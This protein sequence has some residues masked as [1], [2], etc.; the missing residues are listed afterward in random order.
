MQSKT[1][2]K[3]TCRQHT[4][5][6]MQ[7]HYHLREYR[8]TMANNLIACWESPAPNQINHHSNQLFGQLNNT[9]Q[10]KQQ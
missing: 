1:P 7:L 2:N 6:V 10:I 8:V 9:K 4:G 3:K 5:Y